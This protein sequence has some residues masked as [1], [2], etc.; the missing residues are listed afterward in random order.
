M[1]NE[2]EA[3]DKNEQENDEKS[4]KQ[5]KIRFPTKKPKKADGNQPFK[6][7]SEAS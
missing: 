7:N 6:F 4:E 3:C 5:P 2:D 1:D